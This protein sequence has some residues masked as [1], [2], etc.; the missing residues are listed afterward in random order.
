MTQNSVNDKKKYCERCDKLGFDKC[1]CT[2]TISTNAKWQQIIGAIPSTLKS[3]FIGSSAQIGDAGLIIY[4]PSPQAN[5]EQIKHR[6]EPVY[7]APKVE[8]HFGN[9]EIHYQ[10]ALP[11]MPKIEPD[12]AED[13][14]DY[15]GVYHNPEN[16]II[17]PEKRE[18]AATQYYRKK[19]RPLLGPTLS[20]LVRELRQRCHFKSR[21]NK[22][23]TTYKSLAD[24][25]GV[26][27]PT[28]KRALKRDSEGNFENKYLHYFIADIQVIKVSNGQSN[29][30]TTGTRFLIYLDDTLIPE[31]KQDLRRDQFDT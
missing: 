5:V 14:D 2:S 29:I 1:L 18:Y 20:E 19:W 16:A 31:D 10:A 11:N 15:L 13:E 30:R 26:S 7:I 12:L 17:Q 9:I 25:L 23:E 21:R 28:I 22:F 24:G 27:V 8:K 6:I 4:L 3:H